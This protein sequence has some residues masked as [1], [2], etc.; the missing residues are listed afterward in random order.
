MAVQNGSI[1]RRR[2]W[3]IAGA[4]A[5]A[6]TVLIGAKTLVFA[7]GESHGPHSAER[8]AGHVEHVVKFMLSDL[9]AT[10]QQ[11]A[12]VTSILQAT[13]RD[14][15]A[16]V[17]QHHAAHKQLHEILSAP[18]VDRGRLEALRAGELRLA[19]EASKR[20]LEGV[21]DAAEVL[22]PEQRALLSSN[23]EE[24]RHWRRGWH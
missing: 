18:A 2:G 21:A 7:Q 4:I 14:V 6:L 16:F 9:D 10:D 22:T 3:M 15:H 11:K 17:D 5:V 20:L 8:L 24:H 13:A 23:I 12:Q 19:D 1:I